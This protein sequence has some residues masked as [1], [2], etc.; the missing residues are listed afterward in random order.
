MNVF[1]PDRAR[2][3][4]EISDPVLVLSGITKEFLNLDAI[5]HFLKRLY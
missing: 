2:V 1:L 4:G 3:N 5:C